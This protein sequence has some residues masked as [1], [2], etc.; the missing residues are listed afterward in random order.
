MTS[1]EKDKDKQ[2]KE[3]NIV[4]SEVIKHA[5]TQAAIEAAKARVKAITEGSRRPA[6]GTGQASTTKGMR[7]RTGG[8]LLKHQDFNWESKDK[9]IEL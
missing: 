6:K 2:A 3:S 8:P 5:I 4:N 7:V 9:Y 1:K